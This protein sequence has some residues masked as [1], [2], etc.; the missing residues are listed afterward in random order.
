MTTY[1]GPLTKE[2]PWYELQPVEP[3]RESA[4]VVERKEPFDASKVQIRAEPFDETRLKIA[5]HESAHALC[6]W[7]YGI[8]TK[9]AWIKREGN[10]V[11]GACELIDGQNMPCYQSMVALLVGEANDLLRFGK[12]PWEDS[13]DRMASQRL[14]MRIE[15]EK[16][17]HEW[18]GNVFKRAWRDARKFVEDNKKAITVLGFMLYDEGS[19]TGDAVSIVAGMCPAEKA[20]RADDVLRTRPGMLTAA[21]S[22]SPEFTDPNDP[23]TQ[24]LY[25]RAV[26]FW[27][28]YHATR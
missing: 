26:A 21:R 23:L 14:A 17:E 5:Q 16:P 19:V 1:R 4:A 13:H 9:N 2:K 27:S 22:G 18:W 12:E 15:K 3:Q 28:E 11:H 20:A 6:H 25:G 24:K 10:K 8:R 7:S